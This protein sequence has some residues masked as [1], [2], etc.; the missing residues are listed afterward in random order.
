MKKSLLTFFHVGTPKY[1]LIWAAL[2]GVGATIVSASD[3]LSPRFSAWLFGLGILM[4]IAGLVV[5]LVGMVAER[6]EW[7]A[8]QQKL[9]D[10]QVQHF[11]RQRF[12]KDIF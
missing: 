2:L 3:S 9:A 5:W 11:L 6:R 7:Q 1:L 12:L 8:K 10:E 4:V